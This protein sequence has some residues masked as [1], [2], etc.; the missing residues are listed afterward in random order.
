LIDAPQ[1]L[2][3]LVGNEA[4]FRWN[5]TADLGTPVVVTYSF[6]T[7]LP[8]YD[9]RNAGREHAAYSDAHKVHV[10]T[11]LE[12]WA[13]AG[14]LTFVEVPD[15]IGG[16]I[17][18]SFL[19]M[20]GI[21]N[22]AGNQASGWAYYPSYDWLT[23]P[24][25]QLE[26]FS[27]NNNVGG[28][29]ILNLSYYSTAPSTI[30]PGQR[31][32]SIL[33]HEIG[34]ALGLKHPF[35]GTPQI[36]PGFD[37]GYYTVM[38]YNRSQGTTGLG[39][40][41][42]E[43]MRLLYGPRSE[44]LAAR[45]DAEQGRL[46][47][48]G[49]VGDD[50]LIAT[51]VQSHLSGGHGSDRFTLSRMGDHLIDG[52]EGEDSVILP[53]WRLDYTITGTLAEMVVQSGAMTARLRNVEWLN[54]IDQRVSAEELFP[55]GITLLGTEGNDTLI[56]TTGD[57]VLSDRAGNDLLSGGFGNDLLDGGAGNDTLFGGHGMDTLYGGN[58]NDF[59]AG[60]VGRDRLYG[61]NGDDTLVG[62]RG[63]DR[64]FGG[65]GNDRLNGGGNDD[66]LY[67]G[68]GSDR[69]TGGEGADTFI[70]RA[71]SES[72]AGSTRDRIMDFE[73]GIDRIDISALHP[74]LVRVVAFTGVAGQVV[75][76]QSTG[77]L[78]VDITGNSAADF[79]IAL[80]AGTVLGADDLIL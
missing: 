37:S 19:D 73:T 42:I 54:F 14:G 25:G 72:S 55:R 7:S 18:F 10:R 41:D 58:Q 31:G 45:W 11:A 17:Q 70:W 50:H 53:G 66:L 20:Q 8:S 40:L 68:A 80:T 15:Q 63:N 38:S 32:Y 6:P 52:G 2:R 43:A 28:D 49:S 13:M 30:S 74:D 27:S 47:I 22:S 79:S 24:D 33:L 16:D 5:I 67:A 78:S 62:G 48:A 1:N 59:L 44:A 75:Y 9:T 57:D 77:I 36:D 46:I 39:L 64:L 76:A 34:H 12:T 3:A 29:V 71:A 35:E 21:L 69:L 65:N 26:K 51:H 23:G 61:G 60:E 56:G 4:L